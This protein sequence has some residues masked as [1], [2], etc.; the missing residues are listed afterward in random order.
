[1]KNGRDLLRH[2]RDAFDFF[3]VQPFYS[4]PRRIDRFSPKGSKPV[5][6]TF[7]P[8]S[9]PPEYEYKVQNTHSEDV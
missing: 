3:S 2:D 1:M 6:S 5:S 8:I 7:F 4:F 9:I